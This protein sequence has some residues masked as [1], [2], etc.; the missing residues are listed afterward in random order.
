MST[1]K[2]PAV[3]KLIAIV[4]VTVTVFWGVKQIGNETASA[5]SVFEVKAS[6]RGN[7]T[8]S[9]S[10]SGSVRPLITVDIGSQLS[11][12]INA[13]YADYNDE[14]A[15]G[16][17][18]ARIDPQT[19][20][21]TVK[22]A[23]AQLAVA[24]ASVEVQK[25]TIERAKALLEEAERQVNRQRE[26]RRND[27]IAESTLDTAVSNHK[28][29]MAD[30]TSANAS[31]QNAEATVA[32]R[33]ASLDQA[34]IDLHRT[35]IRS[36]IDGTVIERSV[37]VG[38]TV[39]ASLSAPTLFKLAQDLSEIQVEADVDEADIGAVQSGNRVEFG[40][41]AYPE[42][43]FNGNVKQIRLSPDESSNVVTYTVIITAQ[44][45]DRAL[46]PGMTANV[47][48]FTGEK[49]DVV[50]IDNSAL[51]FRPSENTIV[52]MPERPQRNG[53]RGQ[54]MA[55]LVAELDLTET[56]QSDLRNTMR[57]LRP[58]RAARENTGNR[59]IAMGPPQNETRTQDRV[60]MRQRLE[61]AQDKAL[62]AILTDDQ[63]TK[64][65]VLK[66][67][68]ANVRRSQVW[69]LADDNTLRPA[70]VVLGLSDDN[71]TEVIG[72]LEPGAQVV[73]RE[74]RASQ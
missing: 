15:E 45:R 16:A 52:D 55:R 11:G 18:L 60:Q 47:E 69:L 24:K 53:D 70:R 13:L 7:I 74:T 30:L 23:E 59:G 48:I 50:R 19:F 3:T 36:P 37:D 71:F 43:V 26:L 9:V 20:E 72:G 5:G 62:R 4:L 10:A 51:R 42:R 61:A 38:Q 22:Q 58:Q 66:K 1:M 33:Q 64:Y 17:L 57:E 46:L 41:D 49:P 73:T 31:L 34:K 35:E 32:Q 14:V 29:A 67:E 25:A 54:A 56:Q 12:Q 8:Q 21:T 6:D 28:A 39:A 27:T 2:R 68:R 40:V 63:W 65:E 44:N